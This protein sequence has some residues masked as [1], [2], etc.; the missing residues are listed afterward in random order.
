MENERSLRIDSIFLFIFAVV[1]LGISALASSTDGSAI[2]SLFLAIVT[3]TCAVVCS[4]CER[5][6]KAL[7]ARIEQLEQQAMPPTP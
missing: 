1:I 6:F 5:Q 4:S 2:V 3:S 7:R